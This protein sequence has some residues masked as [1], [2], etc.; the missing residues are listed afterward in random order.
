MTKKLAIIYG[1]LDEPEYEQ[2]RA[3]AQFIADHIDKDR[4]ETVLFDAQKDL[5]SLLQDAQVDLAFD[6]SLGLL[7]NK[8]LVKTL[9]DLI[10]LP[11]LGSNPNI[12]RTTYT[13]SFIDAV[14]DDAFMQSDFPNAHTAKKMVI[15]KE[16]YEH[17]DLRE[18]FDLASKTRELP[19]F[20]RSN[21][22]KSSDVQRKVRNTD[23]FIVGLEQI[24]EHDDEASLEEWIEGA[25]VSVPVVGNGSDAFCLP[26]L[27]HSRKETFVPLRR[28]TLSSNPEQAEAM[29]A[30]LERAALE[31]YWSYGVKDYGL[32]HLEWDGRAIVLDV[33]ANPAMGL[34]SDFVLSAELTEGG[35]KEILSFILDDTNL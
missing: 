28:E 29:Y 24:F 17:F 9:L 7:S 26:I 21:Y 13:R 32:I 19:L 3:Q 30:T 20:L 12:V 10:G 33:E 27:E 23:I 31:S 8:A 16:L 2:S 5:V 18:A 14:F 34:K 4:Y 1:G 11:Y 25:I 15:T 22:Q 35:F 6:A